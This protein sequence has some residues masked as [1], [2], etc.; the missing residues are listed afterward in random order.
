[1][2]HYHGGPIT[3]DK[4]AREVWTRRHG[5]V[6]FAHQ[7]QMALAAEICQS[8]ALDNGAFSA[9]KDGR[10]V[11]WPRYYDWV[12]EWVLH[13]GFDFAVIPDEI[14]GGEAENDAL[15]DEWPLERWQ[16]VPVWHMHE[17]LDRLTRLANEWP[18]VAL[19]SSG[20]YATVGDDR[21]WE[22][23]AYAMPAVTNDEGRPICK[24]HGLRMLNPTV[25]SHLPLASADSTNV[26]RNIGMD[27]R[28]KT[29]YLRGLSKAARAAVL[30]D[31]T[32]AHASASKWSSRPQQMNFDLLG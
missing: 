27:E 9:W 24:L 30:V 26:A 7:Q 5:F 13:P 3:P 18:R 21:W 20:E 29:G 32:E 22:R 15:I 12:S 28:W 19:G 8:F 31:R 10:S 6:S 25:F 23:M 4:A 1:M 11:D 14:E 2:I 16:G 17:S